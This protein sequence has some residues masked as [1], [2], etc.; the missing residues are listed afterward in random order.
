MRVAIRARWSGCR[1]RAGFVVWVFWIF[2]KLWMDDR[3]SP[4]SYFCLTWVFLYIVELGY[5]PYRKLSSY[6][7][8]SDCTYTC[9][10]DSNRMCLASGLWLQLFEWSEH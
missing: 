10:Y 3:F 6:V 4:F 1:L 2:G 7:T 9:S 8:L 5:L